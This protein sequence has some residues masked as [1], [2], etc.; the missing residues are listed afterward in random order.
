MEEAMMKDDDLETLRSSVNSQP[1]GLALTT[2]I[3]ELRKHLTVLHGNVN[4]LRMERQGQDDILD[5]TAQSIEGLQ[6]VVDELLVKIISSR[7][8]SIENT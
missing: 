5:A 4:I 6:T 1:L 8:D 2:V 7:I 3:Y